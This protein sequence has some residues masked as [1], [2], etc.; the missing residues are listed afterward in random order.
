MTR[1]ES[2]TPLAASDSFPG[3]FDH[4]VPNAARIYDYLLGGSASYEADRQAAKLILRAVPDA[5]RAARDNRAFLGRAVR[6]LAGTEGIS[7]FLDI[8]TGL[9]TTTPAHQL[10][11]QVR[12]DAR[13]VYADHD[14]VVVAH[15]RA[16]LAGGP[17]DEPPPGAAML[18]DL[19][20][21]EKLLDAPAVRDVIDF[22]RPVGVLLVAI[23][24]FVP[25]DAD[26]AGIV[27][28]LTSRLAPGSCLVISHA[29]ADFLTP[30]AA[31]TARAAYARASVPAV[32]R[33]RDQVA[34]LF[35]G[36]AMIPPGLS[37]INGW[38]P[39]LAGYEPGRVLFW[40]GAGRVRAR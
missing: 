14:P 20:D 24:H 29:T 15:A 8:G 38:R 37:D 27:A 33:T 36:L 16:L 7:Q 21:P 26:P 22:S 17:P 4:N 31:L 32:P 1:P 18:A 13:V 2:V 5:R 12:P 3:P 10:A 11:R 35:D 30:E 6:Y 25:D 34:A 23:L 19:R 9:P 39:A 28:A 40:A